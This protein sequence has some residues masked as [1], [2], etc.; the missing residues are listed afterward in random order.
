LL[1]KN[2]IRDEFSE[3]GTKKMKSKFISMIDKKTYYLD[4]NLKTVA[5]QNGTVRTLGYDTQRRLMSDQI[6]TFGTGVD[7]SVVKFGRSY[8]ALGLLEKI[9]AYGSGNSIL[10]E[11]KFEYDSNNRLIRKYDAHNGNV[12]VANTPF[13]AYTYDDTASNGLIQNAGRLASVDYPGG[14]HVVYSYGSQDSIEDV[15]NQINSISVGNT[16]V[17]QYNYS[18][19]NKLMQVS[20]PEPG[21]SLTYQNGGLDRYGRIVNHAWIEGNQPLVHIIH[22]YDYAGN[23]THR[24]DAVDAASSELYS[25]DDANQI[26]VLQHGELDSNFETINNANFSESWDFDKTGNWTEYSKNGTTQTRTANAANQILSIDNSA[27]TLAHDAN[28][29]M[30]KTPNPDESGLHFVFKY[31]AWNRVTAVYE[32]DGTTKVAEYVYNGLGH[33]ITKKTYSGGTLS[34][35]RNYF[36]NENWQ[37]I[38]ERVNN[39]VDRTYVW[40]TRGIDDLILRDRDEERLYPLTDPN[41]NVVAIIDSTGDVKER[42]RYDAFGKVTYLNP[43]FSTRTGSQYDWE[44]LF[45]SRRL[46]NETGLMYY[47]NRYY[48]PVIGRFTNV[49]PL[50]YAAGD[51]NLYRYVNNQPGVKVD[52]FGKEIIPDYP[53][54]D[55]PSPECPTYTVNDFWND[56]LNDMQNDMNIVIQTTSEVWDTVGSTVID[57]GLYIG[58]KAEYIPPIVGKI[59]GIIGGIGI[60]LDTDWSMTKPGY[61]ADHVP[62]PPYLPLYPTTIPSSPQPITNPDNDDDLIWIDD[63]GCNGLQCFPKPKPHF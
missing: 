24:Y 40:G 46:D 27:S 1:Y 35:T 43:D 28:G 55:P 42:Y 53:I 18:S 32:A 20:L 57:I 12:N 39:M 36:Y 15:L 11:T 54:M 2:E 26:K 51:V 30:L 50:G 6:T 56:M 5:D 33:R 34:E 22:G 37:C 31:D 9:S 13:L 60:F 4:S 7:S 17:S 38:E 63:G 19:N 49:D 52:P 45:T 10:N 25:Y 61:D 21:T 16:S 62:Q 48:H 47:R 3:N 23:R 58:E 29:N 41:G 59:T 14:K 44:F 8:S